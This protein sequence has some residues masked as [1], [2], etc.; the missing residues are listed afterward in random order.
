MNYEQAQVVKAMNKHWVDYNTDNGVILD[1]VILP[2]PANQATLNQ[3][4]RLYAQD[5]P[6]EPN[7]NLPPYEIYILFG[8]KG[9]LPEQLQEQE[10]LLLSDFL[11]RNIS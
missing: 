7:K 8:R 9:L 5:I 4:A 2:Y 6:Y 11:N 3:V 10:V 1:L